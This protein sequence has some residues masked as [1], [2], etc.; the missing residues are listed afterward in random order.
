MRAIYI[1]LIIKMNNVDY[2]VPYAVHPGEYIK[3]ELEARDL[4]QKDFAEILGINKT[5]VSM[6]I[7]GKRNITPRLATRMGEAF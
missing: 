3:M 1:L 7:N 4:K 6:I 5:E 2:N